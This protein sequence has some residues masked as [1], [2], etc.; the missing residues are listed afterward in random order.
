MKSS[1]DGVIVPV[2][3]PLVNESLVTKEDAKEAMTRIQKQIREEE[4]A[5]ED[6]S[7]SLTAKHE[8]VDAVEL[9]IKLKIQ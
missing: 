7:H 6:A 4:V 2:D 5:I 1:Q 3:V 9:A 8:V